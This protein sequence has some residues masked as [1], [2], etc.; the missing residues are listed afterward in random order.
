MA[1]D[2][3]VIK[4]DL[5]CPIGQPDIDLPADQTVRHGI[6]RLV[7]VD[8]V[9][10]MNLGDLPFRV[11][12]RCWWQWYELGALDL[13]EQGSPGFAIPAHRSAVKV[14]DQSADADIEIDKA[15]E[16]VVSKSGQ[17]PPLDD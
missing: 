4:E 5:D 9:I 15:E 3:L 8:V 13:I 16:A 12:K 2:P 11:F 6:E 17:N 14:L 7:D 1:G 10:G